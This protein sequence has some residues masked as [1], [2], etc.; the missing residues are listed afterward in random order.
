MR[1][2]VPSNLELSKRTGITPAHAG[3]STS[4]QT[5]C[6]ARWDHPRACGEKANLIATDWEKQGSPPRMRGKVIHFCTNFVKNGI[7]PAHAGKSELQHIGDAQTRD[8]PR[9]C[10]EKTKKIP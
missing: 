2:K 3:K 10:G 9:A 4:F 8:H 5:V 1:G 7:T 6:R